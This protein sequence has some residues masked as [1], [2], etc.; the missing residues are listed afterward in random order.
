MIVKLRSASISTAVFIMAISFSATGQSRFHVAVQAEGGLYVFN[1]ENSLPLLENG[2]FIGGYGINAS[3]GGWLYKNYGLAVDIQY[4]RSNANSPLVFYYSDG[5]PGTVSAFYGRVALNEFSSDIDLRYF[6][7]SW[8]QF[9]LGPTFAM[10][11]RT[12]EVPHANISDRLDSYCLGAHAVAAA[13]LPLNKDKGG[14]FYWYYT[15][16]LRYLHSLF[17]DARGRDLSGYHQA[18]LTTSL[19]AGVGYA[20]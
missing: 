14:G 15:L 12:S 3:L 6:T 10:I 17:F 18:F 9:G 7:T 4:F 5:T 13:I 19:G 8:L 11:S 2:K 16:K 20:F 1:S